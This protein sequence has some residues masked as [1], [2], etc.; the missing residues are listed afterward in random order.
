MEIEKD[1]SSYNKKIGLI[2]KC[3]KK[4]IEKIT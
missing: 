1:Y 3:K 4:K 2:N